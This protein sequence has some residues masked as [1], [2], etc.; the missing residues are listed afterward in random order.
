[1]YARGATPMPKPSPTGY[2]TDCNV[3]GNRATC[4]T[5]AHEDEYG[6]AAA[7]LAEAIAFRVRLSSCMKSLG[8]VPGTKEGKS[9]AKGKTE[10]KETE[11]N[12]TEVNKTE[13][14]ETRLAA[15]QGDADAQYNL[16]VMYQKGKGVVQ[17][18]VVAHMYFNVA[19]FGGEQSAMQ[20]IALIEEDMTPS[21]IVEAQK[22]AREWIKKHP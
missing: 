2:T 4:N 6:N 1:M 21:Q 9:A 15:E 17:D 22:L 19:G 11:V 10:V 14:K 7:T 18:Y 13:F 12:K 16:G 20:Q 8:W 3:H 5:S